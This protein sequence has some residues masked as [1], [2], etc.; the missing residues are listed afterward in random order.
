MLASASMQH[1]FAEAIH[2]NA[3]ISVPPK[4]PIKTP[5]IM[6]YEGQVVAVTAMMV[7][8]KLDS[9]AWCRGLVFRSHGG[10]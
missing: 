3:S 6:S 7:I 2:V 8:C 9:P 5:R 1:P 4:A 10:N